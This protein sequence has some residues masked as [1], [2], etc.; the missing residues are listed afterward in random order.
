MKA[1]K[2]QRMVAEEYARILKV[3]KRS[4]QESMA[5][6]LRKFKAEHILTSSE[7]CAVDFLTKVWKCIDST[8]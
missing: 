1:T 6:A 8:A 3:G 2:G 5:R 4:K 7:P